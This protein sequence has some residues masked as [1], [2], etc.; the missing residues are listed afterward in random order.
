MG[1]KTVVAL[2]GIIIA[3]CA[4]WDEPQLGS[5]TQAVGQEKQ[6][7]SVKGY[8]SW[9]DIEYKGV[10]WDGTSLHG[11]S[12]GA[13]NE[14]ETVIIGGML[15]IRR[16]RPDRIL[17]ERRPDA[18]CY[19]SWPVGIRSC[20]SVNLS[21]SPSPLAGTRW[22][23]KFRRADGTP[24][25]GVVQIGAS[26]SHRGT[27]RKDTS[28]ALFRLADHAG[29][30]AV[31]TPE[32]DPECNNPEGCRQNC[33][34]W[35][36]DV[37]I[38][39][40]DGV[41]MPA[42]PAG[43]IAIAV[44]G[45][46]SVNGQR[47]A[48]D[49]QFTFGCTSGTAAKCTQWGFRPWGSARKICPLADYHQSCVRAAMADYCADGLSFT[50]KGTLID[51]S[52]VTVNGQSF[53]LPTR[54][55]LVMDKLA[56]ALV[57]E[58]TFDKWSAATID[59]PRYTDLVPGP[60]TEH[61]PACLGT[62][63][64]QGNRQHRTSMDIDLSSSLEIASTTA[65]AHTEHTSGRWLHRNCSRCTD[66]L[67]AQ[68]NTA[69]CT[70]PLDTRGWDAACVSAAQSC[71]AAFPPVPIMGIHSECNEGA[72]LQRLDSGCTMSVCS[73]PQYAGCCT[74]GAL[75]WSEGCVK[76]ANRTCT[77]GREG[78]TQTGLGF[79]RTRL[80]DTQL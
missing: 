67:S 30:C 23:G 77:G 44:P 4:S 71:S 14:W 1:S 27:V 37:R 41:A 55:G 80:Y 54:G 25:D 60:A 33:D 72:G 35:L 29:G 12:D 15:S 31:V 16:L 52:D 56:T 34:L 24:F 45:V 10:Q 42:C 7:T 62:Y 79:C 78:D 73:D 64:K 17:E 9:H 36:Y 21:V 58:A 53:L 22:V 39:R 48:S 8:A 13:S 74:A 76:A 65:C 63:E 70:D 2:A 68:A 43:E 46:Y 11:V 59:H 49:D 40:S 66:R 18:I 61:P 50:K 38:A 3:G 51:I 57:Y 69:Y 19:Q 20:T 6:S 5:H 28:N 75:Q 47:S 26:S 32:D